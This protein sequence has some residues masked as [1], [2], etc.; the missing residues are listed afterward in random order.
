MKEPQEILQEYLDGVD[1]VL[2]GKPPKK[3]MAEIERTRLMFLSSIEMI[4]HGII[5]KRDPKTI[6]Y[7]NAIVDAQDEK[8]QFHIAMNTMKT[9]KIAKQGIEISNL[10]RSVAKKNIK[11]DELLGLPKF[12]YL[13][14]NSNE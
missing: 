12:S 4:N 2:L 3:E 11:L 13:T 1:Q 10:R 9:E 14:K 8:L 5:T 6:G 7:I